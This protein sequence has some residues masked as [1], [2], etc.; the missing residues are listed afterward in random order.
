MLAT[1]KR[2]LAQFSYTIVKQQ[3]GMLRDG[4]QFF[5][6]LDLEYPISEVA[7]VTLSC[8]I[9]NS[10]NKTLAMGFVAGSRVFVCDNLAL[11]SNLLVKRKHTLN[12]SRDFVAQIIAAV[13]KLSAFAR[14]ENS[15]IDNLRSRELG[16]AEAD[17][18]IVR[19]FETGVISIRELPLVL[20][21]WRHPSYADF[22]DRTAWSLFN[23]YTT[24]LKP[25]ATSQPGIYTQKVMSLYKLFSDN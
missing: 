18:Q 21:E 3:L 9:R 12:G 5:G 1:V 16:H 2:T 13:G 19:S 24:A 22:E 7:G 8:G 17:S 20:Q 10:I 25:L 11:R 15:L 14:E 23:A 6:T 4:T